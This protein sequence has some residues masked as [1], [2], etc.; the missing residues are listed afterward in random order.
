[1]DVRNVSVVWGVIGIVAYGYWTASIAAA[2]AFMV[3]IGGILEILVLLD[4]L[5]KQFKRM[6][7]VR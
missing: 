7:A 4:Q 2:I 1:M 6:E 5:L 3:L